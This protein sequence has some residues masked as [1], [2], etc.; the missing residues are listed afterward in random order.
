MHML[1][2]APICRRAAIALI[3]AIAG[4]HGFGPSGHMAALPARQVPP[5]LLA[6]PRSEMVELSITR[7]RQTPPPVYCLGPGDVL[8]IYIENVLGDAETPPPVQTADGAGG[9]PCIGYPIAVGE[10]GTIALPMVG[11][12]EVTGLSVAEATR[13]IRAAY[14]VDRQILPE[15]RDRIVVTLARPRTHQ[16]LVV[17]EETG[18]LAGVTKR[19]TGHIV[20]LPAYENDVLHA[21]NRTGGL[22]GIDAQN[23]VL[24]FRGGFQDAAERDLLMAS[25]K[26]NCDPCSAGLPAPDNPNVVRIPLRF[27]PDCVPLFSEPDIILHSG[28]VVLIASRDGERFYTGGAIGSGEYVLPRDRDLDVLEAIA[29]AGGLRGT[30]RLLGHALRP[31]P[32]RAIVVRRTPGG[33]VPIR[34][35]LDEAVTDPA[36]RIL[37]QPDDLILVE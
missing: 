2:V 19:G 29:L 17:R 10:D 18:G 34:V 36:Q 25:L 7:L 16:V 8:G 1:R 20:D 13:A 30:H 12:I 6:R 23:E 21:L 28:D 35:D 22:P 5:E 33:Q 14:T 31:I 27:H 9:T 11:P 37:I 26:A 32:S 4:C 3:A 15:G 24:I